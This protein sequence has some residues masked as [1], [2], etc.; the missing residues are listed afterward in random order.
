MKNKERCMAEDL[1]SKKNF[2]VLLE[3]VLDVRWISETYEKK[4]I[5]VSS[6]EQLKNG[7]ILFMSNESYVTY[8]VPKGVLVLCKG[9]N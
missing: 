1:L 3:A 5:Y 8:I 4:W 7:H 2:E 9:L 6:V